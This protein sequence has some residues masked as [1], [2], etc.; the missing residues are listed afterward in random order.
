MPLLSGRANVCSEIA[1]K[2]DPKKV[3]GEEK[4][5]PWDTS[6]FTFTFVL[7][8]CIATYLRPCR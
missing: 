3:Y 4:S 8:I 2:N 7:M 6:A 5:Q 1:T